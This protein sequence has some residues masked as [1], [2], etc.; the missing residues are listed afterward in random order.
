VTVEL[1]PCA[2][3]AQ[4]A[5]TDTGIGIAP[6]HQ[7]AI[8]EAFHQIDGDAN[9]RFEGTGLGL[10]LV[11]KLLEPMDGTIRVESEAGRGARFV[12]TLP[13]PPSRVVIAGPKPAQSIEVLVAE[14]DDATRHLMVRVLQANGCHARGAADGQRAVEALLEQL[15]TVLVLDLMMPELDG[16]EVLER[17]RALPQ[18]GEV[19]VLVFSATEPPE[20]QQRR[21]KALGAQVLVKGTVAT[22]DLVA[23][24]AALANST[25]RSAA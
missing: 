5:V 6:E 12:V 16:Y 2:L 14:D 3:G 13:R 20:A 23:T 8:F 15:P 17:L 4:L 9:R 22:A 25:V 1:Q 18:G 21:L 24:V 7:A 10:A 19:K 11:K